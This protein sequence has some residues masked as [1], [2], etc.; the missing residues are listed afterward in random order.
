MNVIVRANKESFK[1]GNEVCEATVE[2]FQDEYDA[3][4]KAAKEAGLQQGIEQGIKS[5]IESLQKL[6]MS[7]NTSQEEVREKFN[8]TEEKILLYMEKY[9]NGIKKE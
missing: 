4:V 3:G 7:K 6:G 9:W 2:L 1:E 5:L 8:L